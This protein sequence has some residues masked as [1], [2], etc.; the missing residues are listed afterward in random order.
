MQATANRP[1]VDPKALRKSL[2]TWGAVAAL[3]IIGSQIGWDTIWREGFIR[4][5][6]NALLFLYANVGRSFIVAITI[7][8][9]VLRLITSPL[10][11]KQTR[12][13]KRMSE[14]QPRVAELQ[15]RYGG[16]KERLV[17]E[18]QKLYREAGV[19]PLGGCLPTLIQ[20][21]IWIGLYRSIN[22][23]LADTPLEL[24]DLGK[25]VYAG[26]SAIKD[27]VPLQSRF[28]WLNLAKPDPTPFVLPVLVAGS[29]WLQQKMMTQPSADAQQA[30]MNQ[31]MQLMMPLMFGYFTT[32]FSSGLA[33]YFLISNIVGI[34]MQWGIERLESDTS[35]AALEKVPA[36]SRG[37]PENGSKRQR[38]KAKR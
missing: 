22:S 3:V 27:I 1:R 35:A 14:L 6:L 32:Q 33:L 36:K 15:K 28:L 5:M 30:S 21:P 16:N 18:Q 7:F 31:T 13:S 26:F 8:T 24:M 4:P 9:V 25:D 29:M 20:F 12:S 17:Q 37:K 10:Q 34:V 2:I 19:N 11:I 38:S 23:I